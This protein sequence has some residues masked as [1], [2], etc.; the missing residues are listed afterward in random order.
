MHWI[1]SHLHLLDWTIAQA[2][3]PNPDIDLFKNQVELLKATNAQ[4]SAEFLEKLKFITED[5]KNLHDRFSQ[6]ITTVQAVL[7]LFAVLAAVGGYL[8]GKSL[9]ESREIIREEVKARI[10]NQVHDLVQTEV[11]AVRRSLSREQVI[12]ETTVDYLCLGQSPQEVDFLRSRGFQMVRFYADETSLRTARGTILVIDIYNWL[13][14]D[15]T[16]F[17][18][19]PEGKREQG[20][21]LIDRIVSTIPATAVAIVYVKG[22]VTLPPQQNVVPANTWITLLGAAAD[23]AHLAKA[24]AER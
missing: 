21:N 16:A 1:S 23:A 7:G 10:A 20:Q 6:F 5:N 4:Q 2:P 3:L 14:A 11:A 17:E 18:S 19:L 22:R 8:F 13:Q 9:K 24:V 15:G 12:G